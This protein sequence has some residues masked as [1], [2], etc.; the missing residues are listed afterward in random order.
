VASIGRGCPLTKPVAGICQ[1]DR[2]QARPN[3]NPSGHSSTLANACQVCPNANPSGH[4]G[5][6]ANASS[7]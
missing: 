2:F 5:T 6:H 7:S 3:A 1:G 4:G